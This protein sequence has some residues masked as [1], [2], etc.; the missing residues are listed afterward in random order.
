MEPPPVLLYQRI[1]GAEGS[2]SV[3]KGKVFSLSP[4]NTTLQKIT[5]VP[6]RFMNSLPEDKLRTPQEILIILRA[7]TL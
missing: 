6:Y 5:K 4:T 2:Q 1:I 7:E 3:S